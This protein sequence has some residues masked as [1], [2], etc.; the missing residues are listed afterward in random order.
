MF[1]FFFPI[2]S[3]TIRLPCEKENTLFMVRESTIL[4]LQLS[5][6]VIVVVLVTTLLKNN[7]QKD[8][9]LYNPSM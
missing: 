4:R 9:M 6:A 3:F 1:F 7:S 5:V 2:D 8:R